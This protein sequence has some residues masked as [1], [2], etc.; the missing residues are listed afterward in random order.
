MGQKYFYQESKNNGK[1]RKNGKNNENRKCS[2]EEWQAKSREDIRKS[3]MS[4]E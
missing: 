3:V 1:I 2:Q 4:G